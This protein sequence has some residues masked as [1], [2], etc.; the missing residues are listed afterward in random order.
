MIVVSSSHSAPDL[1]DDAVVLPEP[2]A[3]ERYRPPS[4]VFMPRANPV[5]EMLLA[6][7]G[8]TVPTPDKEENEDEA[9]VSFLSDLK[10]QIEEA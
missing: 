3:H 10:T 6:H 4:F 9:L 1:D 7:W 2:Q 8:I 5:Q